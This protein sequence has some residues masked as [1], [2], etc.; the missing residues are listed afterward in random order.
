MTNIQL[1]KLIE[2]SD[3]LREDAKEIIKIFGILTDHR[4][5]EVINNWDNIAQKIKVSRQWLEKEKEILLT[6][7]L[8]EIQKD[9]ELYN[10][11]LIKNKLIW[12]SKNN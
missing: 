9:I 4:K 7:T 8:A 2:E 12:T 5:I 1:L 3:I 10:K 6:N 11:S